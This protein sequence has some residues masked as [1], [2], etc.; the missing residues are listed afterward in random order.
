MRDREKI[1]IYKEKL[2][3]ILSKAYRRS[4]ILSC[5]PQKLGITCNLYPRICIVT[6]IDRE[7]G[8]KHLYIGAPVGIV[9]KGE[10]YPYPDL[11]QK[12]Y[13]CTGEIR[14]AVEAGPQGVR[15]F[16]YGNDLLAASVKKIY[17]PFGRGDIVG[18][19][20]TEDGRV[21]GVGRA[22]LDP[23]E[24]LRA[25]AAGRNTEAAVENVFDLGWFLRILKPVAE[26]Y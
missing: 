19:I 3:W 18:V 16:L 13:E 14:S 26:E 9:I 21:I 5:I 25:R 17:R 2:V 22:S 8:L 23:E 15:A 11:L 20:D 1:R 6:A 10:I 7:P 12:I 4:E 24:I